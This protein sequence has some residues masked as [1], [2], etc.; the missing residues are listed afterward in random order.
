MACIKD[1]NNDPNCVKEENYF[2]AEFDGETLEPVWSNVGFGYSMYMFSMYRPPQN[3]N[4]WELIVGTQ[5]P[6]IY[7]IIEGQNKKRSLKA[8]NEQRLRN[9]QKADAVG[10]IF[11]GCGKQAKNLLKTFPAKFFSNMRILN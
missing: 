4:N 3:Q 11:C 2:I 6:H 1:D 10:K 7:I 5:Y 9:F 8:K